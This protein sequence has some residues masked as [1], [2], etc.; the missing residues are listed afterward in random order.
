MTDKTNSSSPSIAKGTFVRDATGLTRQLG[1]K[2]AV[3]FNLLNMGIP[4]T[5]L[6]LVFAAQLFPGVNLPLTV[7]LG[8]PLV[9]VTALTYY[10]LTSIMPRTGGDFVWVG[11]II[12]PS[13]GFMNNFA[14]AVFFLAFMGPVSGWLFQYGIG[15][16]LINLSTDT[17]NAIYANLAGQLSGPIPTFVA[18][19]IVLGVITVASVAGL[20]WNFRFQWA[21]FVLLIAGVLTFL[22]VMATTSNSQFMANF[23]SKSGLDY[24]TVIS[25][26]QSTGY[27]T[28]FTL[29]GT[30]LG[31]VFSFLNY[32]GFNFSTF[33]A[34]EVKNS[35]RSQLIG[36]IGAAA[37]FAFFM[38]IVFESAYIVMGQPFLHA[39]SY[40][41]SITTNS[42][43]TL[44][45][46]P[47]LQYLVIFANSNPIVG[48]LVPLAIIGSVFGSL[49]TIMTAVVRQTFAW[50]F[51]RVIPTKFADL[52]SRWG[53]PIYALGLVVVVSLLFIALNAFTTIL[54]YL[55]YSTSGLWATTG[56]VGLAA[57]I[58]PFKRKDLLGYFVSNRRWALVVS[59]ILTFLGGLA[60]AA[61]ALSPA[62]LQATTGGSAISPL[63]ILGLF[64][65][66]IVG[67]AIY[68]ISWG[69]RKSRGIDLS[70]NMKEIP[71]E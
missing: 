10:L 64:L 22:V 71:P 7:L 20:K 49:L 51:D 3:M 43:W 8:F 32:Y 50:S 44:Q 30:L 40:L 63:N 12:H 34:G 57:A 68:F 37:I 29:T 28:G 9:V 24:A 31:S 35:K 21:M 4:W 26:A 14:L 48:I 17:G 47:V 19:L 41:A 11:R 60:V 53:S 23:N 38:F 1:A 62:Y 69:I 13:I 55:S 70:L 27:N 33:I 39:A 18:G 65:T 6:Y 56:V 58:L 66:F 42:P 36:I 5:F 15:T 25:A 2:D 45:S 16:I 61:I 59:G 46:P 52:D 67:I 54:Q